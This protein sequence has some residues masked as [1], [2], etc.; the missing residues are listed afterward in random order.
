[1]NT[2]KE[3]CI[4]LKLNAVCTYI[5]S[6]VVVTSQVVIVVGDQY[7][8]QMLTVVLHCLVSIIAFN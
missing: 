3:D 4:A 5:E 8:V 1:L 2:T 6:T 7:I